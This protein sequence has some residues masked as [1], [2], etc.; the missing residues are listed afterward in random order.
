M[1]GKSLHYGHAGN[2][3]AQGGYF[4]AHGGGK[5]HPPFPDGTGFSTFYFCPFGR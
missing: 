1:Q 5:G 4:R 3:G 2:I